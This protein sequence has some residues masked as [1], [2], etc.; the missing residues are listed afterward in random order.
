MTVFVINMARSTAR[1]QRVAARLAELGV[2]WERVEA[3]DDS[4][5]DETARRRAFSR[6]GWWCCTLAPIVRGQLGCAMSHQLAQR[7][8]ID[9]GLDVAC[10]LEDDVVLHDRFPD[11]LRWVED[12]LDP[13]RAQVALFAGAAIAVI[14]VGRELASGKSVKVLEAG[15]AVLF[16][17]LGLYV[18]LV[19]AA[20]TILGVRLAVDTGLL[21]IVLIS[22][23]I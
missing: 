22:I 2:E 15:T 6:L 3:I 21:A 16:G 19:Q 9:R 4:T 8:M 13:A 14:L 5:L 10:V 12:H 20:W 17:A 18:T 7:A 11:A 23:A 1:L